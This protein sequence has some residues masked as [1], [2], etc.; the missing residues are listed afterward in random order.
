MMLRAPTCFAVLCCAGL[1]LILSGFLSASA[2]AGGVSPPAFER[3]NALY[4]EGRFADASAA[5]EDAVR[6]GRYSANLFYNLGDAYARLGQR[7]RSILNYQRALILEPSHAEARANLAFVQGRPGAQ[8]G[9]EN[10]WLATRT[11]MPDI[12]FW[13]ILAAASGWLALV[14]LLTG[15][16]H[17]RNGL[18]GAIA[19]LAVCVFAAGWTAWLDGGVKDPGR[20]IVVSD[21]S[22][23]LYSPADNSKAITDLPAGSEVRILSVQGAWIYAQLASG[24]RGWFAAASLEK[25]IPPAATLTK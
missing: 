1:S 11:G 17:R 6:T 25:V 18:W 9:I 4:A 21:G 10:T 5:Y 13:P 12:D 23:A 20:A 3:G 2:L 7:G 22:A 16:S 14:L 15:R 19:C 24:E 8:A